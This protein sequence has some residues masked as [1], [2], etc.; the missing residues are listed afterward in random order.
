MGIGK[1]R[2]FD[3][4]TIDAGPKIPNQFQDT[5]LHPVGRPSPFIVGVFAQW[6]LLG[7]PQKTTYNIFTR[8]TPEA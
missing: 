3:P 6:P 5:S 7:S 4:V 8:P 1:L 2:L